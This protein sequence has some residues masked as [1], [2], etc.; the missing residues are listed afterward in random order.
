[1]KS[2]GFRF[3]ICFFGLSASVLAAGEGSLEGSLRVLQT[4]ASAAA[5]IEGAVR[6]FLLL[7]TRRRKQVYTQKLVV[8]WARLHVVWFGSAV[9]GRDISTSD[10]D[11][12]ALTDPS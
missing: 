8:R 6:S 11:E 9:C 2:L 7:Y 12:M 3:C 4:L 10:V 5:G 1:M